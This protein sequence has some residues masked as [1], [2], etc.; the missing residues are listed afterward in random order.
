MPGQ[1]ARSMRTCARNMESPCWRSGH[2]RPWD[3]MRCLEGYSSNVDEMAWNLYLLVWKWCITLK[4]KHVDVDFHR[5][6]RESKPLDFGSFFF[7]LSDTPRWFCF[8]TQ[9]QT[10]KLGIS[11]PQ[12]ILPNSGWC[13][14]TW[15]C[16]FQLGFESSQLTHI[17]QRGGSTINRTPNPKGQKSK[18]RRLTAT[19]RCPRSPRPRQT[20]LQRGRSEETSRCRV[21]EP[22]VSQNY[23][24]LWGC[25]P[26]KTSEMI[27]SMII[28]TN[29][30]TWI[31][32]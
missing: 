21:Y 16:H 19:A 25:E 10:E 14:G 22:G 27:I 28:P 23:G 2:E 31:N 32:I 8:E 30:T 12:T 11:I 18:S 1:R 15:I 4:T 17:V 9:S 26:T 29:C 3:A 5:E 13:F 20:P 7:H 24:I 6:T